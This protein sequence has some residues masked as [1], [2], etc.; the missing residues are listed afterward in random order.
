MAFDD[1]DDELWS[2]RNG[3]LDESDELASTARLLRGGRQAPIRIK[4]RAPKGRASRPMTEIAHRLLPSIVRYAASD[5]VVT[6]FHLHQTFLSRRTLP[7]MPK[8]VL[9]GER[10][11]VWPQRG[12]VKFV[13]S[14][15]GAKH[16]KRE[17]L[18]TVPASS[19]FLRT[20]LGRVL[21]SDV[22]RAAWCAARGKRS[23]VMARR[24]AT[25]FARYVVRDG[26]LAHRR[27]ELIHDLR[28]AIIEGS[29]GHSAA[30]LTEFW[31]A[32]DKAEKR[33]DS[34]IQERL[35]VELPCWLKPSDMREILR[36]FG[37]EF[38]TRNLPWIG[39]AHLPD[40]HGDPRNFHLHIVVGTRPHVGWEIGFD[41]GQDGRP[42]IRRQAPIFADSKDRSTQ[43]EAW[44][45][46]LRQRYADITND[47][48]RAAAERDGTMIPRIFFP[49]SNA[50][51]GLPSVPTAHLG[52]RRNAIAR[53]ANERGEAVPEIRARRG[54][55]ER[56]LVQ[57][58]RGLD[59]DRDALLALVA[60]LHRHGDAHPGAVTVD[61]HRQTLL[62]EA[63]AATDAIERCEA[64]I[65]AFVRR[66]EADGAGIGADAGAPIHDGLSINDLIDQARGAV[67]DA[68][69]AE[70][71]FVREIESVRRAAQE[72][73]ARRRE[74]QEREKAIAEAARAPARPTVS[75]ARELTREVAL[76]FPDQ[77]TLPARSET[78]QPVTP[79]GA[80]IR[81]TRS[82]ESNAA[83][84]R[85][86]DARDRAASP[87]VR[88]KPRKPTTA[89]VKK[90]PP[91][92]E[93]LIAAFPFWARHWDDQDAYAKLR[94][95][96]YG[97]GFQFSKEVDPAWVLERLVERLSNATWL[98]APQQGRE[99]VV[100]KGRG[101]V[102]HIGDLK[103]IEITY[104]RSQGWDVDGA[105]ARLNGPL[106]AAFIDAY[107][108][109]PRD[110]WVQ[111]FKSLLSHVALAPG[112]R[113]VQSE[114]RTEIKDAWIHVRDGIGTLDTN[115]APR[116]TMERLQVRLD[117][118]Y[119][120]AHGD[121]PLIQSILKTIV[122]NRHADD[123]DMPLALI[124]KRKL[125]TGMYLDAPEAVGMSADES[126]ELQSEAARLAVIP[127]T[128][129]WPDRPYLSS[130]IHHDRE[131]ERRQAEELAAEEAE[132][133]RERLEEEARRSQPSL[134]RLIGR[135]ILSWFDRGEMERR[136]APVPRYEEPRRSPEP[137]PR[138]SSATPQ[139]TATEAPKPITPPSPATPPAAQPR[140]RDSG[141]ER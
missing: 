120:E 76:P 114:A 6:T 80:T 58:I 28:G 40:K 62:R 38:S 113:E 5:A 105:N 42:A 63:D 74:A 69:I 85:T 83:T 71:A 14:V 50:E 24:Q 10:T 56:R 16:H 127:L 66:L 61:V 49:G 104:S 84:A 136:P 11:P 110:F 20:K 98:P 12:Q 55:E 130:D 103:P 87:P 125:D 89:N 100:R 64:W 21:A 60:R 133:A 139:S 65:A 118:G 93:P 132:L 135:E 73:E 34:R 22:A 36:Q 126:A 67:A 2:S 23:A 137:T 27:D 41:V 37:E 115:I 112:I 124:V 4:S 47:V 54:S 111:T 68:H 8:A 119:V 43:G 102:V 90:P 106:P 26:D 30:E 128:R 97:S 81:P 129:P 116:G 138:P 57:A 78:T 32:A 94:R 48:A 17:R 77:A 122:Y 96:T 140:R 35:I 33:V 44:I 31:T 7:T 13:K 3:K 82:L 53:R 72:A 123:A 141:W 19:R 15:A 95:I 75:P 117:G 59:A 109:T 108:R 101:L 91:S 70:Q 46:H 29:L 99:R 107:P 52:S 25:W 92:M 88:K 18:W 79:T 51:L 39:A 9:R 131:Q 86:P 121:N 134:L 1:F 45:A